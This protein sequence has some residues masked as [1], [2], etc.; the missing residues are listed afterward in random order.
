[1]EKKTV[2]ALA[3]L[4]TILVASF[5]LVAPISV[6]APPSIMATHRYIVM[7]GI[8]KGCSDI[9]RGADPDPTLDWKTPIQTRPPDFMP[10]LAEQSITFSDPWE[11]PGYGWIVN[12]TVPHESYVGLNHVW[13]DKTSYLWYNMTVTLEEDGYGW[14]FLNAT[15]DVDCYTEDKDTG[16]WWVSPSPEAGTQAAE[17]GDIADLPDVGPDGVGGTTDDGFGDGTP[18]PP[19]SSL[20]LLP[21]TLTCYYWSGGKWQLLFS[22][23]WPQPGTTGTASDMVNQ[24][25]SDLDGWGGSVTGKPW[26][27]YAGLDHDEYDP[28]PYGHPKWN[29]YVHYVCA[30]SVLHVDTDLGDLDVVFYMEEK[31]VRDD[32]QIGDVDCNELVD[33]MDILVAGMAFGAQD[34]GPGPDGTPETPDDKKDADPNYNAKADIC[35]DRGLIDIMD[36]LVMAMDFGKT[37]TPDCIVIP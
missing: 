14:I 3:T 32:C 8:V 31:K 5:V 2:L 9:N 4:W 20:L 28:V 1:M 26:E 11:L 24:A 7:G 18:D 12:L 30:W 23:P 29:A 34:E 10:K 17:T 37:L 33:I 16:V 19:G 13:Y 27:F 21:T 25:E 35:D 15:G 22:G 6:D 36:I